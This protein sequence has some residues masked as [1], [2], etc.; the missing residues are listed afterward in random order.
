[1]HLL[2]GQIAGWEGW[3]QYALASHTPSLYFEAANYKGFLDNSDSFGYA[4]SGETRPVKP[5]CLSPASAQ[6]SKHPKSAVFAG[7]LT[8]PH[9]KAAWGCSRVGEKAR[10]VTGMN[11]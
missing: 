11:T 8:L 2:Q 4:W 6:Y 10:V 1:M 9:R 5:A 3:R 7:H